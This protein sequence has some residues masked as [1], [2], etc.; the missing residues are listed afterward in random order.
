MELVPIIKQTLTIVTILFLVVLVFS[1]AA[2]KFKKDKP[3]HVKKVSPKGKI[4]KNI[5]IVKN[6]NKHKNNQ[7]QSIKP[8]VIKEENKRP[9]SASSAQPDKKS[10]NSEKIKRKYHRHVRPPQNKQK[11]KNSEPNPR[12]EK[13]VEV[14]RDLNSSK[15]K[16]NKNDSG[17]IGFN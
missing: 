16:I 17:G 9:Y 5:K 13:R 10:S 6:S 1:Y 2:S 7:I 4:K 14:I 15:S 12:I 11:Q 8:Q 3:K